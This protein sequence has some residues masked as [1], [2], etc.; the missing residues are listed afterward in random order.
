[1]MWASKANKRKSV[2]EKQVRQ[3]DNVGNHPSLDAL[4]LRYDKYIQ[5]EAKSNGKTAVAD[6]VVDANV[7]L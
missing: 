2:F 4:S 3:K 1:M 7:F 5:G 6:Y